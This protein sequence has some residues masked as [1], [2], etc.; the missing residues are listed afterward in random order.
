MF[1][2]QAYLDK[3]TRSDDLDRFKYLQALVTEYQDTERKGKLSHKGVHYRTSLRIY[4]CRP[5]VV[6]EQGHSVLGVYVVYCM[7]TYIDTLTAM[8][9]AIAIMFVDTD[10]ILLFVLLYA[11]L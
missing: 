8:M 4:V 1:S 2:S 5:R 6:C 7:H 11:S 3:R 10:M 9:R